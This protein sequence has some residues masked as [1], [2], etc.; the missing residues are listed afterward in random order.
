MNPNEKARMTI[1]LLDNGNVTVTG[2]LDDKILSY[3]M[4]EIAKQIV[5]KHKEEPLVKL[6]QPAIIPAKPN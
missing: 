6:A 4:L 1:S 3:G 2:P 5:Q